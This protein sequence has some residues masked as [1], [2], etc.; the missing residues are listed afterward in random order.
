MA[1]KKATKYPPGITEEMVLQAKQKYGEAG[2]VKYIDLYDGE[3][4]MLLT[5]LAVR[6]KRQIVQEFE[7]SQYDPKTAKEVLVNN[8]LLSHKDKVKADDVLFEAAFNGISELLPIG[9]HSFHLPEEFGTLP[10][11]ITKSMIDEAVAD[12]RI[13]IRI[14][15]LASG[16]SE[17]DFVHVLMCA[18]TRAAISDHQRWRAE[19]P[20]KARS[21]LLKSALLSHADTVSKNDFLYYT[22]AAAAIELKPKAAAV[23]KNL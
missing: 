11:G 21:I 12:N 10:E 7:R 15:K 22:G 16:E 1:E 14:V 3:G 6:P 18:P 19:N 2:Y 5:V 13:S 17:K 9:R 8:C 4:E 20:N 23:V